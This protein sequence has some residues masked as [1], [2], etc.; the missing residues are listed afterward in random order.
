MSDEKYEFDK[1]LERGKEGRSELYGWF[2]SDV[3]VSKAGRKARERGYE[4]GAA[5]RQ[6]AESIAERGHK[7]HGSGNSR[8]YKSSSSG[9]HGSFSSTAF[10]VCAI[11]Y[12][13]VVAGAIFLIGK[14]AT[15]SLVWWLCVLAIL[16]GIPIYIALAYA[17]FWVMIGLMGLLLLVTLVQH[18]ANNIY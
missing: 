14:V 15:W 1:G 18:F 2:E 12:L 5:A 7:K 17:A 11:A 3:F 13:F 9:G 16:A 4:A 8:T 10:F 6:T